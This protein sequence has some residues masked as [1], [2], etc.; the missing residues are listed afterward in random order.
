MLL[1]T[2][3]RLLPNTN[4]AVK[5]FFTGA[6]VGP[7]IDTLHN[8]CL[9][10]YTVLPIDI[11]FAFPANEV[12]P[13]VAFSASSSWLIPPLLGVSYVI[14]GGV[15]PRLIKAVVLSSFSFSSGSL[16][17]A[18]RV[19][20]RQQLHEPIR[21]KLS[22]TAIIAVL[23]TAMI[24]RLSEY[25]QTTYTATTNGEYATYNLMIMSVLALAQWTVLGKNLITRK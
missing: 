7:L 6:T 16:P 2:S 11:H 21:R 23:S 8:Q 10:E 15:L 19:D 5:L 20:A 4:T 14:L 17:V 1:Q 25:L 18:S 9:L 22:L 3:S 13:L 24:I 12:P